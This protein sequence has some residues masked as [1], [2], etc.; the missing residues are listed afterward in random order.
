MQNELNRINSDVNAF[1]DFVF[2]S[3]GLA[4]ENPSWNYDPLSRDYR[5][6]RHTHFRDDLSRLGDVDRMLYSLRYSED[7]YSDARAIFQSRISSQSVPDICILNVIL[8]IVV[9]NTDSTDILSNLVERFISYRCSCLEHYTETSLSDI[10]THWIITHG[11]IPK[12]EEV[13]LI[14]V[15]FNRLLTPIYEEPSERKTAI[16]LATKC[17]HTEDPLVGEV[18]PLCFGSF[19]AGQIVA[20]LDPCK[21]SFHSSLEECLGDA[22]VSNWLDR[23]ATCPLCKSEVK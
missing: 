20:V 10:Y 14:I 7:F 5:D 13:P 17:L 18:C 19:E 16:Q 6:P 8:D 1:F 23:K 15:L 12:C 2:Y 4:F 3:N 9:E 11:S 21:H 22:N